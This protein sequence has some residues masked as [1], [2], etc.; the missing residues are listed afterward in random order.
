MLYAS[1]SKDRAVYFWYRTEYFHANTV[2]AAR[3]AGLDPSRNYRVRELDRE[4]RPLS[5]EGKLFSGRFLMENGL[6]IPS[7]NTAPGPHRDFASHVLY[8]QAE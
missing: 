7:A 4:G 2:P 6:D 8:L 5:F 1:P 3:M